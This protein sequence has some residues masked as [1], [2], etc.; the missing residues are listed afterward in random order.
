MLRGKQR[1][2]LFENKVLKKIFSSVVD[3][4]TR[5]LRELH[6]EELHSYSPNMIIKSKRMRWAGHVEC[7]E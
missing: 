1:L 6:I 4:A 3:E 2:S 5:W 7:M